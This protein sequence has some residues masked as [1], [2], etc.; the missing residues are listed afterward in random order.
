MENN[1]SLSIFIDTQKAKKF[2]CYICYNIPFG[3]SIVDH[4]KCDS[5]FCFSCIT[6]WIKKKNKCP[7][8]G[9]EFGVP[10]LAKEGNRILYNILQD[11]DV[12]CPFNTSVCT[13]VGNYADLPKHFED[14]R[15]KYKLVDCPY[16]IAGCKKC[17]VKEII[18]THLTEEALFHSQLVT[19]YK[20][21]SEE[22]INFL[23][24]Q[25]KRDRDEI[26]IKHMQ[27]IYI[28]PGLLSGTSIYYRRGNP[29][30]FLDIAINGLYKGTLILHLF[31]NVVPKTVEN[32]R[33]LC[34]GS[35]KNSNGKALHYKGTYV[36]RIVTDFIIQAGDVVNDNGTGSASIYGKY[37]A[38]E[39]FFLRHEREGIASMANSG[40]NTNGCQFFI[41]LKAYPDLDGKYVV[42]GEV[43]Q[44]FELMK[45]I[46]SY[47][48]RT[49]E[50]EPK[51]KIMITNCGELT[52]N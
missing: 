9:E 1:Y 3:T 34:K 32:F 17:A 20:K 14:D 41:T 39:N 5:V 12:K 35:Y 43:I 31:A 26:Y 25:N 15:K 7:N 18:D 37:F 46:G 21:Q 42:F 47:G 10:V 40:P 19:L 36:N 50:G 51:A 38:D 33:Q 48:S 30:A 22:Q 16:K 6:E 2:C 49:P 44:G 4:S 29:V 13:W 27:A 11:F 28:Y 52:V 8:C 24:I 23:E 45:E